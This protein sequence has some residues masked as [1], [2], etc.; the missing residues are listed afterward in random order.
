M[1][2]GQWGTVCTRAGNPP[3]HVRDR[4]LLREDPSLEL[5]DDSRKRRIFGHASQF[6]RLRCGLQHRQ[7]GRMSRMLLVDALEYHRQLGARQRNLSAV[8]L[9]PDKTV[10]L[11]WFCRQP[12][13]KVEPRVH[14]AGSALSVSPGTDSHGCAV[15]R[16]KETPS[17][18]RS[19]G[20]YLT[21]LRTYGSRTTESTGSRRLL[22]LLHRSAGSSRLPP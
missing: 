10:L 21:L 17:V 19:G 7:S 14:L 22:M 8:G 1:A 20:R 6:T 12:E 13:P 3:Y 15:D 2:T 11:Q 4:C 18:L 16:R 9:R 5:S